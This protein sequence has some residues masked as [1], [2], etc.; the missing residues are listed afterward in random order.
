MPIPEIL[1]VDRQHVGDIDLLYVVKLKTPGKLR[2]VLKQMEQL[3][4]NVTRMS[5]EELE[6][7]LHRIKLQLENA[8]SDLDKDERE[9]LQ[10]LEF[11]H[12]PP[13][14]DWPTRDDIS[15]LIE[16]HSPRG[17]KTEGQSGGR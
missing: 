1:L 10:N 2:R 5:K 6:S 9:V 4:M 8:M 3:D 16:S 13:Y 11:R 7:E 17:W 15:S 12:L 14:R